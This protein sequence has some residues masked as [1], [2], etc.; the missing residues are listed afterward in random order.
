MHSLSSIVDSG[1][2]VKIVNFFPADKRQFVVRNI[3]KG[4]RDGWE[5]E[6]FT[7]RVFNKGPSLIVVKATTG[8]ICGGYTSKHWKESRVYIRDDDAFVFSLHNNTK[9]TPSNYDNA[10]GTRYKG[11]CFGN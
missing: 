3:Y 5:T 11:F 9:Y 1:M 6:K 2:A 7:S 4:S 10:I 8:R